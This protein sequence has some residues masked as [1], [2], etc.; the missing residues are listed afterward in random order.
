MEVPQDPVAPSPGTEA[1]RLGLRELPAEEKPQ[2]QSPPAPVS[3]ADAAP[4]QAAAPVFNEPLPPLPETP[5]WMLPGGVGIS[6]VQPFDSHEP[7]NVGGSFDVGSF[8]M[9]GDGKPSIDLELYAE[10]IV[11]GRAQPGQTLQVNGR[12]VA[13]NADGTFRVQ[14]A[15]P[16]KE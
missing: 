6:P 10:I 7:P 8:A 2:A 9:G 15:L 16:R 4:T 14:W 11:Y 13:V 12:P 3:S 1:L 5:E